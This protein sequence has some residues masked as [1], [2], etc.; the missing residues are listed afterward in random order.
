MSGDIAANTQAGSQ[1]AETLRSLLGGYTS[2][3]LGPA[4]GA[5][6]VASSYAH[7]GDVAGRITAAMQAWDA[8]VAADAQAVVDACKAFDEA[9][10]VVAL[11]LGV[12]GR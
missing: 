2:F 11:A 7:D 1:L 6:P 12:T 9:D 4:A 3:R 5:A 8:L 10:A